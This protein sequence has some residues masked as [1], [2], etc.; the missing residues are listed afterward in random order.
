MNQLNVIS[1]F[2]EKKIVHGKTTVG[3]ASYTKNLLINLKKLKPDLSIKV[4]GETLTKKQEKYQED[5]IEIER[6]WKRGSLTSIFSLFFRILKNKEIDY[7]ISLEAYMFGP[8]WFNFFVLFF[9][10]LMK[11]RRKNVYLILHQV[12]DRFNFAYLPLIWTANKIFVFEENFRKNLFNSKKV[13]FIPHAVENISLNKKQK[14]N[15]NYFLFFGYL[16]PYKGIEFLI[17]NWQKDYPPLVIAG[18]INPNHR[19][20]KKYLNYFHKLKTLAIG[21]KITFNGFVPQDK[22]SSYFSKAIAVIL[23]Y[24]M[25]FS[26]SGPL[27]FCFSFEKPFLLS[28][29]LEKYFDSWDFTSAL[30]KTGLIK[31]DFIFDFAPQSLAQKIDWAMKNKEK[32]SRFSALMKE[33]R[34][35]DK[36]AKMYL[37]QLIK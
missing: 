33:K 31:E 18:G 24:K 15:E 12:V 32:L 27:S 17:E 34:S 13:I 9:L 37:K 16:S 3:V 7:L 25:F 22:I 20:N 1:S 5:G 10:L 8:I 6:S 4:Y 11:I 26:S 21:K 30:Q 36:V 35:W 23:P 2:P 29:P 14:I 19:H 28:R